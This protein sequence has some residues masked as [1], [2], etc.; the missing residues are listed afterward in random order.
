MGQKGTS[1]RWLNQKG[2]SLGK[3]STQCQELPD[4]SAYVFDYPISLCFAGSSVGVILSYKAIGR[5]RFCERNRTTIVSD[6]QSIASTVL[7]LSFKSLGEISAL[8][9]FSCIVAGPCQD[10]GKTTEIR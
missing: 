5:E 8:T 9:E 2:Q 7:L 3:W 1:V 10:K 4:Y 6:Y